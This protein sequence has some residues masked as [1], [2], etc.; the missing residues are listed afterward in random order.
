MI[1]KVVVLPQP[2][3]PRIDTKS[4]FFTENEISFNTL[5]LPLYDFAKS[6]TYKFAN[7][8]APISKFI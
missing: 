3:G 4:P 8:I 1:L 2:E 5:V 7:L 6:F